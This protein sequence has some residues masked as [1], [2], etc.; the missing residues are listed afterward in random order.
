MDISFEDASKYVLLAKR[1]QKSIESLTELPTIKLTP[2][3]MLIMELNAIIDAGKY[4]YITIAQIEEHMRSRT[5]FQF[6]KQELKNDIDL[7]FLTSPESPYPG[8]MDYYL[9]RMESLVNAYSGNERRKWGIE[10]PGLCLLLAWTVEIVQ[11][12]GGWHPPEE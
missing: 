5:V 12:D 2:F 7:S 4:N 8:F 11:Q 1:I 6:L 9:K 10:H 3:T